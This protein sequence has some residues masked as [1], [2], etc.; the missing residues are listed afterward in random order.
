MAGKMV[1]WDCYDIRKFAT[2]K[3][4]TFIDIGAGMGDTCIMPLM[5]MGQVRVIGFEVSEK[6]WKQ[7]QKTCDIWG[8]AGVEVYRAGIASYSP[9]FIDN[10]SN[11][12]SNPLPEATEENQT[13]VDGYKLTEM[14]SKFEV[15]TS[16]PYIIKCDCEGGEKAI[17][18]EGQPALDIAK[19]ATQLMW[20]MHPGIGGGT[21]EEWK[22]FFDE[23]YETHELRWG[24]WY[25]KNNPEE[26]RYVWVPFKDYG[27]LCPP[28]AGKYLCVNAVS[29]EWMKDRIDRGIPETDWFA[30]TKDH[31]P[32]WYSAIE[33]EPELFSDDLI[34]CSTR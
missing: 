22:P 21:G 30:W 5:I 25:K 17:V 16:K 27:K 18:D 9:I 10:N 19:G 13:Q 20:E 6:P 15:D 32:N 31:M 1:K 2:D 11:T 34:K 26:A 4:G 7:L 24:N 8:G 29:R 28:G 12:A 33:E 14:F 23:L 3:I